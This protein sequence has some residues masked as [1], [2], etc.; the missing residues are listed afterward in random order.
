M[1]E[2]GQSG[3]K[4]Q[5]SGVVLLAVVSVIVL[6]YFYSPQPTVIVPLGT[7]YPLKAGN[8]EAI[9]FILNRDVRVNG[10]FSAPNGVSFYIMSSNQFESFS[11]TGQVST[12]LFTTGRVT[13][14]SITANIARSSNSLYYFVF[15]NDNTPSESTV[16]ILQSITIT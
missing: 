11:S 9:S 8:H 2:S 5:V 10:M 7:V 12:Y 6:G 13:R 3:W 1:Y 16:T 14:G 4:G 15:R